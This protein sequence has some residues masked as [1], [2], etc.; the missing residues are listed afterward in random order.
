MIKRQINATLLWNVF[1]LDI[2]SVLETK[3]FII[4]AEFAIFGRKYKELGD[5]SSLGRRETA[6]LSIFWKKCTIVM[7]GTQI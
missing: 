5:C 1:S 2:L 7:N 4:A 3:G 6:Y